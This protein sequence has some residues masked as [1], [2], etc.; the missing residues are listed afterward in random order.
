ML[1]RSPGGATGDVTAAGGGGDDVAGGRTGRLVFAP[2]LR[3]LPVAGAG[4][5]DVLEPGA[6]PPT[7]GLAFGGIQGGMSDW[8]TEC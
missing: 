1:P 4:A 5:R 3:L 8:S 2:E 6:L 7:V